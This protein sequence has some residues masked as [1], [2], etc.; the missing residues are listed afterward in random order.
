MVKFRSVTAASGI[1]NWQVVGDNI[2]SFGRGD[3]GHVVINVGDEAVQASVSSDL[4]AGRYCDVISGGSSEN[5]CSGV[6]V[7]VGNN[8]EIE[9]SLEPLSMIAIHSEAKLTSQAGM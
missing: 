4:P 1:T 3:L 5:G 6:S 8:G 7:E 9:V 2:L